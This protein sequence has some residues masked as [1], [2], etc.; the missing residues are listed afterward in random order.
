MID[1]NQIRPHMSVVC[2]ESGERA[3]GDL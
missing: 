3:T 2:S 1:A